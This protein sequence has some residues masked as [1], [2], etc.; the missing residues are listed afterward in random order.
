MIQKAGAARVVP[1]FFAW[2]IC[3]SMP[4]PFAAGE[5]APPIFAENQGRIGLDLFF[6]KFL[7]GIWGSGFAKGEDEGAFPPVPRHSHFRRPKVPRGAHF[8]PRLLV[9]RRA[10]L[11]LVSHR[12]PANSPKNGTFISIFFH[13]LIFP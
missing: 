1:A 6:P 11:A 5:S 8:A 7:F 9:R 10:G 13:F 12:H 3:C 2:A 4:P